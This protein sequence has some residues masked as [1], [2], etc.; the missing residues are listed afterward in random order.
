VASGGPSKPQ[1]LTQK[2][3]LLAGDDLDTFADE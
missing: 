1:S 3:E 2:V